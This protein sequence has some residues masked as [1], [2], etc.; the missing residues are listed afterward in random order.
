MEVRGLMFP[1]KH[2]N[3]DSKEGR[4]DRHAVK[5]TAGRKASGSG[6]TSIGPASYI[7]KMQLKIRS[8]LPKLGTASVRLSPFLRTF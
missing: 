2:T 3:H 6:L 1:I 7:G 5:F 8:H 4:D